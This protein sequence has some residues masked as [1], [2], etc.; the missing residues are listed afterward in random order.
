MKAL[1]ITTPT[2]DCHA[3]VRAW[4]SAFPKAEHFIFDT[5][6][7]NNTWQVVDVAKKLKPDVMF[8]IGPFAGPGVV[9]PTTFQQLRDIGP[10][11]NLCSDA[12]DK[13]W[14]RTLEMYARRDCFD[15]QVSIDGAQDAPVD[16]A[17]LTPVDPK[18]FMF[19]ADRKRTV[20]CG[21]SGNV[22]EWNPRA[23][24]VHALEWFGGLTVRKP[25][26][27]A[28]TVYEHHAAFMASCEMILNTSFTGTGRR[29]HI[30]GRVLEA[31]WAGACLLEHVDSP[32]ADWFDDDC[33]VLYRDPP[34]AAKLI[35]ALPYDDTR[36]CAA[37]LH[38]EVSKRFSARQIYSEIL[39]RVGHSVSKSAA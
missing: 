19:P 38:E 30:K 39:S 27:V 4:D 28:E 33:F 9:K 7:I 5:R 32:I 35:K 11:I 34:D 3:H 24:I 21:F 25:K 23:E 26:Q 2:P 16:F 14:H 13:P 36:H 8:Y 6:Q 29:H 20:R 17:T 31:G 15:L 10:V 37:R 22:G 12:A 1:F 18:P